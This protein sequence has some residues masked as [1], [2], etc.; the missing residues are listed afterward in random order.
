MEQRHLFG[1]FC[2]HPALDAHAEDF[3]GNNCIRVI[4][5]GTDYSKL[6]NNSA[7]L[8]TDYSSVTFDFAHLYKPIVYAQFDRDSFYGNHL[9]EKGYYSYERD[10]FGKICY[11]YESTVNA[12]LETINN[13]FRLDD[14]YKDRIDKSFKYRDR[15][16]CRRVLE[17]IEEL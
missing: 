17:A 12:I 2:V 13:D 4:T 11:D 15:N 10:G 1:V 14:I 5:E 9:Y 6:I 3:C 7:M 16:N 8:I